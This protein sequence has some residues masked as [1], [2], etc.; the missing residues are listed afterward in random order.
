MSAEIELKWEW[1]ANRT[2]DYKL[3]V[4]IDSVDKKNRDSLGFL[5]RHQ[6]LITSLILEHCRV[7]LLSLEVEKVAALLN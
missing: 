5:S 7:K 1:P 2:I 6:S 4:K 3:L